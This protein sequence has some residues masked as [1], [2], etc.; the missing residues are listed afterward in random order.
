MIWDRNQTSALGLLDVAQALE[1]NHSLKN[2]PLPLNDVAQAQ[3]SRPELTARAVHQIQTCLLRNNRAN[4]VSSDHASCLQPLGLVSDRSEQEVNEL[5]QSVQEHMELLGCGAGPQGEAAVHQAEDA[6]QNANF[7]L[8]I[9]PILDEAGNSPSHH[10]Q[11]QQKLESLLGQ[12]GKLCHQDIQDFTQAT[13]D[14]TRSLCPQMLQGPGWR[15]QLE[16]VLVGSK[17]LPELLPE[18]LLQDI[19]TRLRDMRLSVTRTLAESIV[20]QALAGL[21]AAR[22]R[23]VENLAEQAPV[24]MPPALPALDGGESCS[25][26]P[27]E[28]ECLFFPEE[29]KEVEEE[30]EEKDDCPSGKWL[31]PSHCFHLVPSGHRKSRSWGRRVY[32]SGLKLTPLDLG[33]WTP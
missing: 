30:E 13:L 17:G 28:L 2:M 14:T 16:G 9:L 1:Q 27:G 10:W 32:S 24:A 11:L 5:C 23:L 29:E 12:V 25:L 21:S 3:R 18:Q 22:D 19:F 8:S 33:T 26:R 20:T 15:E 7:S 31:E 6:I 4:P